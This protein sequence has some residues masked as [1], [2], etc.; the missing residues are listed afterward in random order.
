MP[1]PAAEITVFLLWKI[2]WP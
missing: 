2:F 1:N